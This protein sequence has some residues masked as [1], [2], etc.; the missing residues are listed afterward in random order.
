[1]NEKKQHD[2]LILFLVYCEGLE[3]KEDMWVGV[4]EVP[5]LP[6]VRGQLVQL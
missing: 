6:R 1:M 2:W 5:G 4:D 3:F